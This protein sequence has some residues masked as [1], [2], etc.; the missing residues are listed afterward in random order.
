MQPSAANFCIMQK[1][2][3]QH[4]EVLD[5]T[6]KVGKI[7]LIKKLEN[8]PMLVKAWKKILMSVTENLNRW[9]HQQL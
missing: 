4:P 6:K 7:F 1:H 3:C 5:G 2:F 8:L 9:I